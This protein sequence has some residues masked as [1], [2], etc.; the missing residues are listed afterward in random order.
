MYASFIKIISS[1]IGKKL[2]DYRGELCTAWRQNTNHIHEYERKFAFFM[3]SCMLIHVIS[4]HL[5]KNNVNVVK[6]LM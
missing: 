4:R 2:T 1:V 6:I 5:Y 3:L